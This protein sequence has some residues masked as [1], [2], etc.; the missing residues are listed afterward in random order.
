[1]AMKS[2]PPTV[3]IKESVVDLTMLSSLDVV[4]EKRIERLSMKVNENLFNFMSSL[5]CVDINK[6]VVR[7]TS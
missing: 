7:W 2:M 6:L 4:A 5:C 3:K 1:M